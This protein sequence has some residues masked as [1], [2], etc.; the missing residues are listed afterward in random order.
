MQAEGKL[1]EGVSRKYPS[2]MKAYGIIARCGKSE[3]EGKGRGSREVGKWG[4][5][6]HICI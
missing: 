5:V 2:A 4:D 3:G 1:P 6:G